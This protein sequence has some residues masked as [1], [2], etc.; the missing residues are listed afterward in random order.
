MGDRRL[1]SIIR[2]YP[3]LLQDPRDE[4]VS[5]SENA[6]HVELSTRYQGMRS[7]PDDD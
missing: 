6:I 5:F 1:V 4:D 3:V 7:V 2:A